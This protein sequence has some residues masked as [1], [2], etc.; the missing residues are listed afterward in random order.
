MKETIY[1]ISDKYKGMFLL[2]SY[3]KTDNG[4]IGDKEYC[5]RDKPFYNNGRAHIFNIITDFKYANKQ[6]G[7][8]Y[9]ILQQYCFKNDIGIKYNAVKKLSDSEMLFKQMWFE[10]NEI[11]EIVEQQY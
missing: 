7:K 10:I 3:V 5:F 4:Y 1:G 2:T 9:E 11:Q 8:P 6:V